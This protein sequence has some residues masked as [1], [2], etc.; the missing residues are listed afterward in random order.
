M[1]YNFV[2]CNTKT[3]IV[4]S[5]MIMKRLIV[6]LMFLGPWIYHPVPAQTVQELEVTGIVTD[7][8]DI[9]IPGVAVLVPGSRTGTTTDANGEFKITVSKNS[10]LLF[11][12]LGY[13]SLEIRANRSH[14]EIELNEDL[15][16]IDE[17]VVVGYGTTTRKNLTTAIATVKPESISKASNSNMSQLL[18]GRAPGL[19]ATVSSAQPGGNVRISIRGAGTPIYIVDGIMMPEGSLEIGD[20]NIGVPSSIDRAGL[21]GLN[22]ND[23]ESIEVLKDA[24]AAI[25]G[26][27]AANGVILITTKKGSRGRMKIDVE[28][29]YSLVRNYKYLD[30][31][32][33]P[34]YMNFANMFSKENYLYNREMYPYGPNEYDNRWMPLFTPEQIDNAIT[35]NWQDYILKTGHIFNEN[36]TVSGGTDR[37]T[38][39]VGGSWYSNEGSVSNSSMER[40]TLRANI[41]AQLF[42][43][44]KLTAIANINQNNYTNSTVGSPTKNQGDHGAGAL[45]A[46]LTYPSS[47]PVKDE[48]GNYSIFRNLPNPVS[49]Q[50]ISDNTRTNGYYYN[51]SLD[52][53]IIKNMLSIRGLFGQNRENAYR[54]LYIPSD[55][56]FGQM[57]KSRGQLG[58]SQRYQT[59]ME[60]MIMFRKQFFNIVNVDAMIGMGRYIDGGSWMDVGYENANDHIGNDNIGAAEGPYYPESGRYKNEKRSQFARVS[61]DILNR[62]IISGTVRRDG[63]D[64]FFPQKKYAWFPSVSLAWKITGEPFMENVRWLNLLKLRASYGETGRDNL[65]TA[66]YGVYIPSD[67]YIMFN[68]NTL[69][70]IPYRMEGADY[71]DVTWEKTIMKNIGL[72]F[73]VLN[74]RIYV[75]FDVFRNDVTDLLG[76]AATAPLD[77]L[78]TRPVNGGHYKR[79]GWDLKINTINISKPNFSWSTELVASRFDARWIE[80]EPNY[81]YEEYQL[82][83]NEPMNVFYY[84]HMTGIINED[85]SNMPES[86]KTLPAAA[87]M[88]GYPIIEDR[89]GDQRISIDDIYMKNLVPSIY[90]GFGNTFRYGNFDLDI[91]LYGELGVQKYNSSYI[92]ADPTGN[93]NPGNWSTAVYSVWSS[94]TNRNG[95]RPGIASIQ[96]V[97][98]P[99]NVGIDKDVQNSSYIRVRNITLGYNFTK[100]NLGAAGKYIDRIR[101]YVDLQNPLTFTGFDR[102]DPEINIDGGVQYPQIRTY[103]FGVRVSF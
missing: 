75:S 56:Y 24:S 45:Q 103:S 80:R 66:V 83:E 14:L 85:R 7:S 84:Y 44:A 5:S 64:K 76:Y 61:F 94:Q 51:F 74:D 98:L 18:L 55:L 27:N 42:P 95:T 77:M 90:L 31:L 71:P 99:G 91:F 19:N 34:E 3:P 93:A 59:T 25:Y 30:M 16:S 22:P 68:N 37:L 88:P 6:F 101:L 57:Y 21:A 40:F 70:Y 48:T 1:I 89:N 41:S 58:N 82:R 49:M 79:Q 28:S 32:S 78:G 86:Q 54:D 2:L 26:V 23:I 60:A 102:F 10:R 20:G 100:N 97:T 29:S 50:S 73:S 52:I 11:T 72:D 15:Q 17:V 46:A 8:E 39:Y 81:D 62:Y 67:W 12:C 35:T 53:D 63:T 69:T 92:W 47:M 38:Y 65:G 96:S 4:N 36:V 9:P 33:G 43:F 87:Q 13:E